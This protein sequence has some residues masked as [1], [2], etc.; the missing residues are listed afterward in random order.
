[1]RTAAS[2]LGLPENAA[3]EKAVA[4]FRSRLGRLEQLEDQKQLTPV[5]RL[6]LHWDAAYAIVTEYRME[7]L[8]ITGQDIAD[9]RPPDPPREL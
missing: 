1:M 9:T 7:Q 6:G 3:M 4:E 5:E 8:E 2:I